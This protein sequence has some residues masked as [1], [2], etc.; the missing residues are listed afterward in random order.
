MTLALVIPGPLDR[1][2]GGY[3]YD[4]DLVEHLERLGHTVAVWSLPLDATG[5]RRAMKAH[6]SGTTPGTPSPELVVFDALVHAPVVGVLETAR[7]ASPVSA[8]SPRWIALVHHLAWLE[9]PHPGAG[10]GSTAAKKALERRFLS[11][12]DA[13][14]F[15]SDDTRQTVA[16]LRAGPKG[17]AAPFR[18]SLVCRPKFP[19]GVPTNP[20]PSGQGRLLFLGNLLPRKNLHGLLKALAL[21]NVRRPALPWTLTLAGSDRFDPQYARECRREAEDAGLAPRLRWEGW[22]SPERRAELLANADLLALPSFHEGWGMAHAEALAQGLPALAVP[23]GAVLE[24]LGDAALWSADTSDALC[25]ALE[26]Y[27]TDGSLREDLGRKARHRALVWRGNATGFAALGAFLEQLVGKDSPHNAQQLSDPPFAFDF[28]RYLEAKAT[29]DDRSLHPRVQAAAIAGKAPQRVVE[30]GGGTGTMA[31]RLLSSGLVQPTTAYELVDQDAASLALAEQKTA[32]LFAPGKFVTRQT[33]LLAYWQQPPQTPQQTGPDLLIAHALLDLFDPRSAAP[34]LAA[35]GARR[36]WL[37]HLFDGQTCWEPALDPALDAQLV[38]AYH[39]SM[40]ER[41][42]G[43]AQGGPRSARDWLNELPRAGFRLVDAAASDWLVRPQGGVYPAQE[44]VFLRSMLH[45]F[46]SS[47]SGRAD[48]DQRGLDWWLAVR[49]AQI[50][51]GEVMFL[52]H[53]FDVVAER[54]A[55]TP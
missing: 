29:V 46:R 36:Y 45:F 2:S 42:P 18:P 8:A 47:L 30:L 51:R 50:D 21:L 48:V 6:L 27:L 7:A 15:N 19:A 9:D 10:K 44:A 4:L 28:G 20:T 53:Q 3:S 14:L 22:V 38:D 17:E 12:M 23:Q 35:L 5:A 49:A 54:E 39:R 41:A 33:D 37:T 43:G 40:T 55:F 26:R 13:F 34:A 25:D 24:V 16:D 11:L 1:R 32:P 31:R 52:A